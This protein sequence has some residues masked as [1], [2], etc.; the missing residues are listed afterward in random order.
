MSRFWFALPVLALTALTLSAQTSGRQRSSATRPQQ[1]ATSERISGRVL[2]AVD[3]HGIA[4]A[5]VTLQQS[6]NAETGGRQP[7]RNNNQDAA[8]ASVRTDAEGRYRLAAPAGKYSLRA[9]AAGY[10]SAAY[11]Q[12]EGFSTAIVL[13]AGLPADALELVL[14]PSAVISGRVL[15]EAGDPVQH[16]QL[17]L[18]REIPGSGLEAVETDSVEGGSQRVQRVRSATANDDGS[19]EFAGVAPGRFFLS[20]S[21]A[22]WYATHPRM[23]QENALYSYRSAIDPALDVAYPEL[24]YP[25]STDSAGA[26]PIVIKG[27]ERI[28]ANFTMQPE[29]ALTLTMRMP[30]GDGPNRVFPQLM[31]SVFGTTEPVQFQMSGQSGQNVVLTGLAPG[32]YTMQTF[33]PGNRLPQMDGTVDLTGGSTSIDLP[34]AG[35]GENA[36]VHATLHTLN[37]AELPSEIQLNLRSMQAATLRPGVLSERTNGTNEVTLASVP[38]GDY[39]FTLFS[40]RRVLNVTGLTVNGKRSSSE[41]LR[42]SGKGNVAVDLT[43]TTY[44]PALEGFVQRDGKPVPGSMVVLVPAGADGSLQLYRRDQ[45]DLDGSF[46]LNNV[47]PGN[48]LL[49]AIDDGW[50]LPRWN[51]AAALTGY[52]AHATPGMIGTSGSSTGRVPET[53]TAQSR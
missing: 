24:F 14:T 34:P 16:A 8:T 48:Y 39:R 31:R 38:P 51:D 7:R 36:T 3:G 33:S 10:L 40:D 11:Q 23:E 9:S 37:G 35:A 53:V 21:G 46:H 44:A 32:R 6:T 12:H 43:V 47:V 30:G 41:T 45:S 52:L 26:A 42:I 17:A 5:T 4:N 50:K 20:A 28:A 15:D 13:G 49:L 22:P 25:S 19:F 2:S 18:Y 27:G 29:R 1:A